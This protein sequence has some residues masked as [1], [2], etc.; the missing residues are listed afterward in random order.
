MVYIVVG[1]CPKSLDTRE[2]PCRE[3][4]PKILGITFPYMKD[5]IAW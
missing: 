3:K 1:N 5:L 4:S 2:F